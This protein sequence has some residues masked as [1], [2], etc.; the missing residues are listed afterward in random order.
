[1]AND[2]FHANIRALRTVNPVLAETLV[3]IDGDDTYSTV[4]YARSGHPVP[5]FHDG[6]PSNSRYNPELEGERAVEGIGPDVFVFFAGITGAYHIRSFLEKNPDAHCACAEISSAALVSLFSVLPL[7]DVVSN[8]RVHLLADLSP[9]TL[10]RELPHRYLPSIH[11]KFQS[12]SLRAWTD[13]F[14]DRIPANLF[15][16]A[17]ESI[18]R[19]FS[20]QAHFG[21]IWFTNFIQNSIISEKQTRYRHRKPDPHLKAVVAAA[22]PSLEDALDDLRSRRGEYVIIST[23]TAYGTLRDSGIIP[24]YYVTIDPQFYSS[25]HCYPAFSPETCIIADV[26]AHNRVILAA[27]HSGSP[28]ILTCGGHPVAHY[29]SARSSLPPLGTGAGT[30]TASAR[31]AAYA[32]GFSSVSIIGAD[33]S[34]RNGKPYARGTYLSHLHDST[35]DRVTPGESRFVSLM[36]RT[37]VRSEVKNGTITYH[38]A[39]LDSYR[40]S[41]DTQA[42]PAPWTAEEY[43]PYRGNTVVQMLRHDLEHCLLADT[44]DSLIFNP[45]LPFYA[46]YQKHHPDESVRSC[47]KK[48]IEL[49]LDMIAR[50]TVVS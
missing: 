36:F 45:M 42:R 35:A 37:P 22:G 49:A 33:F 13:H 41:L 40:R 32:L 43:L 31:D 30:V 17:L 12:C 5:C 20:V 14:S 15:S 3:G 34:Y 9:E 28:L 8:R 10:C 23:D 47:M 25:W 18:T 27:Q 29:A 2:L 26:C 46:W 6:C 19:D 48:T 4:L 24:E 11:G 7:D 1:M 38:T 39:L 21:R 44:G 50:Y 16:S